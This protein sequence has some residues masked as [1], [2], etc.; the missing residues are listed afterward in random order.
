VL[1]ETDPELVP[2]IPVSEV[3]D[4]IELRVFVLAEIA[5]DVFDTV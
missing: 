5:G 3:V 1:A 2:A 4:D